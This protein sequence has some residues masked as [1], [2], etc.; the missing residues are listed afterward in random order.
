MPSHGLL[1]LD[2]RLVWQPHKDRLAQPERLHFA[3]GPARA[4]PRQVL[5]GAKHS[6]IG[7]A[8]QAQRRQHG[9]EVSVFEA[10][11]EPSCANIVGCGRYVLHVG[12]LEVSSLQRL[13][14]T[15]LVEAQ[16]NLQME[17]G[18]GDRCERLFHPGNVLQVAAKVAQI[19]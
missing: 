6:A 13:E 7:V 19:H 4:E 8:H 9:L 2:D 10:E 11:P 16:R 3:H 5:V 14:K 17:F 18:H 15:L 12:A 1:D